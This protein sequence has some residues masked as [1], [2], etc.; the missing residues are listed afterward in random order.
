MER[1]VD[2]KETVDSLA[3]MLEDEVHFA[4]SCG[5]EPFP[6]QVEFLLDSSDRIIFVAGRQVGKSTMTALKGL[7]EC[8]KNPN[9]LVLVLAPTMRQARIVFDK[10]REILISTV[11]SSE[12]LNITRS[13]IEFKNRSKIIC[14]PSGFTGETIRGYTANV[15]IVDEAAYVP[16]E[17]F[18]AVVPALSVTKGKLIL[19]GTPAGKRGYFWEAWNSGEWSKHYAKTEDNPLVPKSFIEEQKA[20]M[21]DL[22]FRQEFLGEFVEEV[23][24]FIPYSLIMKA[25][26]NNLEFEEKPEEGVEYVLGVDLARHGADESAYVI[27]KYDRKSKFWKMV[28][29]ETVAR[30]PLTDAIGRIVDLHRRWRFRKIGIDATGLGAGVY[31]V[32][33]EKIGGGVLV[34][35]NM[36]SQNLREDVYNRMKL[37]L[38]NGEVRIPLDRRLI[39]Q[40]TT[41]GYE[42][43]ETGRMK[44][45]KQENVRDDLADAFTYA[46]YVASGERAIDIDELYSKLEG[47]DLSPD[48]VETESW[49]Y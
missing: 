13:W 39:Q 11:W 25:V 34:E 1:K 49:W 44:I 7:Y 23:G 46:C 5:Y 41:Y 14:L 6:Y 43:K 47:L 29:R 48:R 8:L 4:I 45:V 3:K 15:V 26:D 30:K 40:I 31:D 33:R 28:W 37:M 10:M 24:A 38:E 17:V 18:V 12:V 22:H 21:T 20:S 36:S 35:L 19:L 32:L 16:D 9:Y 42:F 2:E 27:L